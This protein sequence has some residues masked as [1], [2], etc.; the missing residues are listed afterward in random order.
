MNKNY[1]EQ[2]YQ[3]IHERLLLVLDLKNKRDWIYELQTQYNVFSA[4]QKGTM[5]RIG[6]VVCI[7]ESLGISLNWLFY[8]IEPMYVGGNKSDLLDTIT[9]EKEQYNLDLNKLEE[10]ITIIESEHE[11]EVLKLKSKI[12]ELESR[13]QNRNAMEYIIDIFR[14]DHIGNSDLRLSEAIST[15]L[16]PLL[17]YLNNHSDRLLS[18]IK[19]YVDSKKGEENIFKLINLLKGFSDNGSEEDNNSVV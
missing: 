4:W 2:N 1:Y 3:E 6:V 7:C 5:P 16:I 19:D 18:E 12:A 17:S 10:E 11:K 8:G 15:L 13:I 9:E 14:H